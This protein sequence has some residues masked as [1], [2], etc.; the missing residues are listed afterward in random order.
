MQVLKVNE[1]RSK[2]KQHKPLIPVSSENS[3]R[4]KTGSQRSERPCFISKAAPCRQACP[5]GIDIPAALHLASEGKIDDALRT[6]L[7]KNPLPGVCGR[8][9]YHP[10]EADCNR[11]NFDE[12][13]N[14]RS[15]ERFLADNGS[16]EIQKDVS[17]NAKNRRIAIVGSGPAGLSAAYHLA[18]Q[19]Y[20]CTIFEEKPQLGGMLRYV[21]PSY[22]L[23]KSVLNREIERVL[24]LG[25]HTQTG[26]SVGRDLSWSNLDSFDAIF[27]SVG[28]QSGKNLPQTQEY[29]KDV[30]TGLQFLES[31]PAWTLENSVQRVLTVSYTHLT[32][33]TN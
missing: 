20:L 19:G 8:V 26:T 12:P 6:Y 23:P 1:E 24:S 16:V 2:V 15:F 3:L 28:L 31:P 5:I 13:I 29:E 25:I 9:C 30:V 32:L 21:I 18:R 7:M 14:I 11:S 4:F 17:E 27:L 10:C 33:P 22:R